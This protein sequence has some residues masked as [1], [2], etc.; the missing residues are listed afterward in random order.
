[1]VKTTVL[2]QGK[3]GKNFLRFVA[4]E[5]V[6][7]AVGALAEA[8][9]EAEALHRQLEQQA[10]DQLCLQDNIRC[11]RPPFTMS[12]AIF[13]VSPRQLQLAC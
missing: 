10:L 11:A 13:S 8:D 3:M 12:N 5:E 7:A 4:Q 9:E 2:G 6:Q 1:M